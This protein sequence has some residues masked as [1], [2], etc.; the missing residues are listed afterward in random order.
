MSESEFAGGASSNP[1]I[2]YSAALVPLKSNGSSD[3]DGCNDELAVNPHD[4]AKFSIELNRGADAFRTIDQE[5]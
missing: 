3:L 1:R 2:E 4:R 5:A